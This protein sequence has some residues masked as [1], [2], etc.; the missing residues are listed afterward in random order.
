M[1]L[2][3]AFVP[4]HGAQ[5]EEAALKKATIDHSLTSSPPSPPGS[6]CECRRTKKASLV[7]HLTM[8]GRTVSLFISGVPVSI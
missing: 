4:V 8:L 5:R 3:V 2:S 1:A 6:A 7:P